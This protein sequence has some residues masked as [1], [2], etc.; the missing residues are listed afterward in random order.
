MRLMGEKGQ[1]PSKIGVKIQNSHYFQCVSPKTHET[2][3]DW[4]RN[5]EPTSH[6]PNKP[7]LLDNW[8]VG[9]H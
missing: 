8:G 9:S 3:V 7:Y 6:N 2:L 1:K 5:L 4:F